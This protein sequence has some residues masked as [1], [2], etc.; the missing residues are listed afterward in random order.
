MV[1]YPPN[2]VDTIGNKGQIQ[3]KLGNFGHIQ[4]GTTLTAMLV[5]PGHNTQGCQTFNKFFEQNAMILVEAG[6]CPVTT[7]VRNIEKAGG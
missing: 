6:G 7:K 5:F 2:L 3:T 1:T 4:Y